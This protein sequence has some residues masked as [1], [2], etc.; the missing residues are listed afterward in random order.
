M[1]QYTEAFSQSKWKFDNQPDSF[2]FISITPL[3]DLKEY[4]DFVHIRETLLKPFFENKNYPLIDMRSLL[5]SFESDSYE[6]HNLPGFSMLV[7]DRELSSFQEVF[8][9]DSLHPISEFLSF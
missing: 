2:N 1:K 7:L 3:A 9:Y 8:Q 4:L 6:Y 5:P